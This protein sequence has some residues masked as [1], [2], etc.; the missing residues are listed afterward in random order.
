MASHRGRQGQVGA[1]GLRPLTRAASPLANDAETKKPRWGD[2]GFARTDDPDR[3][4]PWGGMIVLANKRRGCGY[5]AAEN[6]D[7]LPHP[8]L[9]PCQRASLC[10]Q[11]VCEPDS[12]CRGWS[13]D[14]FDFFSLSRA[15]A[16]ETKKISGISAN[17]PRP[18]DADRAIFFGD[19]W[20]ALKRPS[21]PIRR[22]RSWSV[23]S[24]F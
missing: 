22:A 15:R 19:P 24:S 10:P 16:R 9:S 14:D 4:N 20:P 12:G 17:C 2:R 1:Y 7:R 3:G 13:I 23:C 5:D 18:P 8:L 21:R 11:A 6:R